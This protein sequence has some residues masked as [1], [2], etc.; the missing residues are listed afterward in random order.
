MLMC[1]Q[2]FYLLFNTELALGCSDQ[3]L[4]RV[5][6]GTTHSETKVEG[7]LE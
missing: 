7:G 1:A 3:R 6:N 4:V 2:V 5:D